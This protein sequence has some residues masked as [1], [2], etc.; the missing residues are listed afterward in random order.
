MKEV[1]RGAGTAL[2]TPFREDLSPDLAALA[3]LVDDTIEGGID[4]LVVM[5]TT[6]ESATLDKDEKTKIARTVVE[7]NR[8]RLPL[9]YGIGGNNTLAVAREIQGMDLSG[10]QAIL[11]VSPYY[12]RPS[13][14]GLF[15]HY[16]HIAAVSPLPI[17]M[18]NVP[19]RTGSNMEARTTLRLATECPN[20]IGVKEASGDMRQIR[21]LITSAPEE[22]YILSGDDFNAAEVILAGGDGVIS[23]L[24]QA[25]PQHF[26]AMVHHA[27][28]GDSV[29]TMEAWKTIEPL[30]KLIF[31]EGNPTGIKALLSLKGLCKP[32]LRLPLVEAGEA[33][34]ASLHEAL[35]QLE[36]LNVKKA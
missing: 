27:M 5:G 13:Q 18:Y 10:Y 32:L 26:T 31:E 17:I 8:G 15:R 3:A 23:V 7:A 14:E 34:M 20:I 6:A 12:N 19:A 35:Q 22:F 11:S 16:R 21:Q 33:L 36:L 9:M 30:C 25:I 2:I 28:S 1:W 24:A 29:S 4:Y